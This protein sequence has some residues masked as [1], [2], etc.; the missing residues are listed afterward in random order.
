MTHES[1]Q[2]VMMRVRFPFYG[3]RGLSETPA[4][5]SQYRAAFG[6][7]AELIIPMAAVTP[8]PMYED[9]WVAFSSMLIV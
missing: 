2:V 4:I 3:H 5:V 8:I 1:F 9:Y 6:K 7:S